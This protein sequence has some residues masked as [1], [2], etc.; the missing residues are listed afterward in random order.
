M[1]KVL[2]TKV[3]EQ[4]PMLVQEEL[5]KAD[6]LK[7]N[8]A[9]RY[10]LPFNYNAQT[11]GDRKMF[12]A[13][14][15]STLRR[16]SLSYPI[17]RA[18]INRRIRQITKLN[19]DITVKDGIENEEGYKA[20]I[21]A[22]KELLQKPMGEGTRMSKFLSVLVDDILTIDATSFEVQKT[23][24]G[25]F[26]H[27]VPVDPTTVVLKVTATG[28]TPQPPEV[29][30]AQYIAGRKIAEFTTE[31][32]I[33]DMMNPRS[34]IPYGL[35]PMES[36]II[37]VESALSGSLYNLSYFKEGNTPEGFLTLPEDI[38]NTP[39][40]L[41]EW[42]DTFDALMAG[43]MRMQR[44]LKIVPFGSVYTPSK[45]PEDMAFEKF[46]L[47]LAQLTC[48]MFEVQPQDI[49]L[50]HQINKS[51]AASQEEVGS[52]RGLYPLA[53]FVREFITDIIQNRIGATDLQFAWVD[54]NP[55]DRKEE[56]EIAQIEVA[57]GAK[58]IDEY[59]IEQ[60][61]E[62]IGLEHYVSGATPIL[63]KD[64]IAGATNPVKMAEQANQAK[65]DQMDS[66]ESDAVK[67]ELEDLRK[68]QKC[69]LK[70]LEDGKPLRTKFAS[71]LISPEV[72]SMIAESLPAVHSKQ[73]AKALFAQFLNP[74]VRASMKLLDL[75]L[76]LRES[77]DA[78]FI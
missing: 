71:K 41:K 61:L 78:T 72:H 69:V 3:N 24:V 49:G 14:P 45:K 52:D 55:T 51:T 76:D 73:Q 50:T 26:M 21:T 65:Q 60:G 9:M 25:G 46:E 15:F 64:I 38:V 33:Y 74:E 27:L 22:I 23:R 54:I 17:A 34:Y 32:L 12:S 6:M 2:E 56:A 57:M 47:W 16:M 28:G 66:K 18:C 35:S 43:D 31:D 39:D 42:Q 44:R 11:D 48:A 5:R 29:A 8:E 67:M 77:E 30:Y 59:R 7:K 1:A 36:L 20:Q 70:D 53:N 19:W 63:V 68:W 37:Q 62:P 58:S 10:R 13:I 75:A 4:V 40:Q